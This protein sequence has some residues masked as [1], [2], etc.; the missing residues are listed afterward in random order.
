MDERSDKIKTAMDDLRHI[1]QAIRSS[2]GI[3]R[4]MDL[5]EALRGTMLQVALLLAAFSAL[6]YLLLL[7]YGS[8]AAI[9]GR[10]R[11]I[12]FAAI[13]LSVITVVSTKIRSI[14]RHVR[15]ISDM[16]L[17]QL[18]L[19]V[20]RPQILSLLTLFLFSLGVIVIFLVLRDLHVYIIPAVSTLLG[21]M[22]VSLV[23]VFHVRELQ[24]LGVWLV[25]GGLIT[26][27]TAEIIHPLWALNLTFTG[28]FMF[29]Y[30]LL[31]A[32]RTGEEK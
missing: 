21:L 11:M 5:G 20:Y 8:Y 28:G 18:L 23:C 22:Y 26:L 31:R 17:R 7:Q 6:Y 10:L 4:F 19:D 16:T 1:K 2:S 3:V 15:Q 9:P 25:L 27:M 32:A 12:T 14:M 29:T 13:L 24:Q 30:F